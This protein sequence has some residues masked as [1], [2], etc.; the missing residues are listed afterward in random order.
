MCSQLEAEIAQLPV[1]E[2]GDFLQ[3]VGLENTGL[4]RLI[5]LVYE[6]MGLMTFFT[7]GPKEARGWTIP[8]NATAY[9]AAGCIH[10]DFQKGFIRAEVMHYA[11]YVA[12]EGTTQGRAVGKVHSE[13]KDYVVQDGDIM[14]FRFN[15]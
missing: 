6:H 10:T 3:S 2:R 5:R 9:D 14:L 7:V 12:W 11:D 4:H 1:Q 15:V 13:G 8:V